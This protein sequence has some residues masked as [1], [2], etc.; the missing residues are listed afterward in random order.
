[1]FNFFK[2]P[3]PKYYNPMHFPSKIY[4]HKDGLIVEDKLVLG[5]DYIFVLDSFVDFTS[6][7]DDGEYPTYSISIDNTDVYFR[8]DIF[9]HNYKTPD[10]APCCRFGVILQKAYHVDCT[11][12]H[13]RI[14]NT[15]YECRRVCEKR[16]AHSLGLED[17]DFP[18][19]DE[20]EALAIMRDTT[21][22][23]NQFIARSRITRRRL[24]WLIDDT[25][26]AVQND[27]DTE[28]K[29]KIQSII[30]SN[31]YVKPA[32]DDVIRRTL[33]EGYNSYEEFLS[34]ISLKE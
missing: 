6:Y 30:D 15:E 32:E 21:K 9:A 23:H 12:V 16:F 20:E 34:Y 7:D 19:K 24:D 10:F 18:Y 13:V 14:T 2:R 26:K 11:I 3:S 31:T 22:P 4:L 5:A 28:F 25:A 1:M 8:D 33:Y 17:L 27:D 29:S